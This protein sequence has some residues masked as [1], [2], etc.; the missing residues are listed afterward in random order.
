MPSVA[1]SALLRATLAS[2]IALGLAA[3][4]CAAPGQ[5][6]VYPYRQSAPAPDV[7]IAIGPQAATTAG[8]QG[9]VGARLPAGTH[10][11]V[12]SQAGTELAAFPLHLAE[13]E[14]VQVA[15][16]LVP[17]RAPVYTLTSSLH[18]KRTVDLGAVAAPAP[19]TPMAHGEADADPTRPA[20]ETQ[21]RGV[22]V[23]SQRLPT[24]DRAAFVDVER[25]S[26][27]VQDTLS[28]ED[29]ARSG[30]ADAASA[31]R[32]VT[33]LSLVGGRFVYVRGL[34]ERYSSVLLN[35][36]QVPSPDPTRRVVPLDLFPTD[37]LDGIL[38]QKTYSS[39][40]PAEFGG[41]TV[42]LQTRGVPERFLLRAQG[43]LGF[44][45]GTTGRDGLRSRGGDRDWLGRDDGFRAAPA[46]LFQRPFPR[47][48][49]AEAQALG[50]DLVARGFAIGRRETGPD[51]G[52]AFSLGNAWQLGD[53]VRA[54]FIG[55]ARY[56]QQWDTREERRA[57]Y[58]VLG[59]GSLVR[60]QDF[61]R[62]LTER[63]IDDSLF[64][65]AGLEL[66]PQ[67]RFGLGSMLFRQTQG[68]DRIDQGLR[69][70]GNVEQAFASEWIE[71][72]LRTHQ[73][74]GEHRPAALGALE[75]DWQYTTSHARR[76]MPYARAYVYAER[77]PGEFVYSTSFPAQV[78]Y[79]ALD[80]ALDESQAVLRYPFDFGATRSLTLRAG[81]SVLERE[82]DSSIFRYSFRHVLRPPA[83]A[84][85]IEQILT[86]GAFTRGE[87]ELLATG[88]ATDFYTAQQSLDALFLAG[89]LSW[90]AWRA[91]LGLRRE[92]NDQQ[93]VTRDPFDA[94]AAPIVARIEATDLLPSG[95]LTWAYSDTA[96]LRL[97]YS[98][99]V[100]RPDFRELSS[101]PYTDPLLDI[102]VIG[103]PA[104]SPAD[105]R[106]A[107]LR[108]EYYFD[109]LESFSVALF[110]KRFER[111]IEL[112][113]TPASGELLELRNAASAGN[114][115]V[116]L[117]LFR[118][119]GFLE[120]A[121]WMPAA[122]RERLRWVDL[123]FGANYAWIDS[124]V[125][126][127][128]NAGIQTSSRRPLQG[129]SPYVAN[130]SVAWIPGDGAS[131]ATLLYHIAGKRISKVGESG[132]PDEYEQPF[133]QLDLTYGRALPWDG[134]TLKLRL[135]NL[136][137]PAAEFRQGSEISRRWRKGREAVLTLE[138]TF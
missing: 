7:E 36:A 38:V 92:A 68:E 30:D 116:E 9:A 46:G 69:A 20:A 84:T 135:R 82:R 34:G 33:G 26:A 41:G 42:Q 59:E 136:L 37:V 39:E 103:N 81:G 1:R 78:R 72:E 74:R 123:Y 25:S 86:P 101:A 70:S 49:G 27:Q 124:E 11:V 2:A 18:G 106:S 10:R 6:W 61:R 79:E 138:W 35:G 126:L 45:H 108:W 65:S 77:D 8:A 43:T 105:I 76:D 125:D 23:E 57:E 134:W 12:L 22:E 121:D 88:R 31:L 71:N 60:Q 24:N 89:D 54:G 44:N 87:L 55:A 115:G 129:Q 96:Q 21:L 80:D 67:H 3:P 32:R 83:T 28:A 118:S 133:G 112:V 113:R 132:V 85:P 94:A 110:D 5:V 63:N 47:S 62:E 128:A 73:V 122:L 137:D 51:T 48:D 91:D 16:T 56:A 14:Q 58:A 127:G 100:S 109:A 107:D 119:F 130:V 90:D 64:L 97:A 75:L 13:D 15:V 53:E 104:L 93:V 19:R 50:A 99:T 120:E 4:A 102:S 40:M 117:D 52:A 29:I 131:E 66:G 95:S 98:R 17:G 111:P 114:R